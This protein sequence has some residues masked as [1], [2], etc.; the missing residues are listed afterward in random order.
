M[1]LQIRIDPR[2]GNS[3]A[4]V[5]FAYCRPE[6]ARCIPDQGEH[7]KSNQ[8]QL[9]VHVEHEADDARQHEDVFKD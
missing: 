2:D 3:N 8:C 6:D 9:P 5:G 7:G 1:L 4:P